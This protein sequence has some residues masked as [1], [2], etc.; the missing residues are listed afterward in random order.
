VAEI[1]KI[2]GDDV[3]KEV[4]FQNNEDRIDCSIRPKNDIP[5][6]GC[7]RHVQSRGRNKSRVQSAIG[8]QASEIPPSHIGEELIAA[9]LIG[10]TSGLNPKG[11]TDEDF[12]VSLDHS[13][14]QVGTITEEFY[15]HVPTLI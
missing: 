10:D 7:G 8:I 5:I 4:V 6:V 9:N 1:Q 13:G 11:S 14:P 2:A 3:L 12:S 15:S